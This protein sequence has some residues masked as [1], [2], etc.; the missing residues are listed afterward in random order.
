MNT[1]GFDFEATRRSVLA[2]LAQKQAEAAQV[3]A[4]KPQKPVKVRRTTTMMWARR[5]TSRNSNRSDYAVSA[6]HLRQASQLLL[7]GQYLPVA[8]RSRDCL[9]INSSRRTP[10]RGR[11]RALSQRFQ[12]MPVITLTN[13]VFLKQFLHKNIKKISSQIYST[14]LFSAIKFFLN[15][16]EAQWLLDH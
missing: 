1:P 3:Q 8:Q 14:R 5:W 12:W 15:A 6:K 7:W 4:E 2:A 9:H 10:V 11:D 16:S 13:F